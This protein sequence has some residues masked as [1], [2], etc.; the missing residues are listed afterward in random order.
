[1]KPLPPSFF[2]RPATTVA[3]DLL[4]ARLVHAPPD[5]PRVVGRIVETEAYMQD[6]PAFHAWGVVD[7][8]TGLVVPEGRAAALFAPPGRAYVYLIYGRYWLLNVVTEREG[9]PGC[10]LI[11]AV[12]PVE[13]WQT[14]WGRRDVRR[15]VDTTNGPGK[16]TLAFDIDKRHHRTDLTRPPLFFAAGALEPGERVAMSSRVGITR[17]IE[18]PWRYFVAGHPSVSPGVPSDVAAARRRRRRR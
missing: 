3:P 15:E 16:L 13:G 6:D 10:V 2:D 7:G 18:H 14:I 17:G 9:I 5:G 1:M 11:R 8:P 12:A 4:G